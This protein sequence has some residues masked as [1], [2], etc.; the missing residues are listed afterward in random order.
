MFYIV[1]PA[2]LILPFDLFRGGGPSRPSPARCGQSRYRGR[3]GAQSI[4]PRDWLLN[5]CCTKFWKREK[6]G[7]EYV[8]SDWVVLHGWDIG[9]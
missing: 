1:Y 7:G 9:H 6:K 8:R 2:L 4:G 3:S 5:G